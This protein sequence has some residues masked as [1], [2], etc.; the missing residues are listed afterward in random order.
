[1]LYPHLNIKT[2]LAIAKKATTEHYLFYGYDASNKALGVYLWDMEESMELPLF[3]ASSIE[4]IIPNY[5]SFPEGAIAYFNADEYLAN[6]PQPLP[7][8]QMPALGM[9][10]SDEILIRLLEFYKEQIDGK[11]TINMEFGVDKKIATIRITRGYQEKNSYLLLINFNENDIYFNLER[12]NTDLNF[13]LSEKPLKRPEEYGFYIAE[14]G[15]LCYLD[16]F[17]ALDL[18]QKG[19]LKL[20]NHSLPYNAFAPH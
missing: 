17:T 4:G 10:L 15:R 5:S 6:K 9:N 16:I 14:G 12:I 8:I 3:I 20:C 2:C 19:L 7:F 18:A 13:I 1:L 11:N